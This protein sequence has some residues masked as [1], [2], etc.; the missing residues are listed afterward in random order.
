MGDGPCQYP[1]IV[2]FKIFSVGAT[3]QYFSGGKVNTA[4]WLIVPPYR[5]G[6]E[7]QRVRLG[8]QAGLSG[9]EGLA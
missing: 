6:L 4:G 2:Y 8:L 9:R 3:G 5:S 7:A 1:G